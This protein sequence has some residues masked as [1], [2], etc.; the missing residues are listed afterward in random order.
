C[1]SNSKCPLREMKHCPAPMTPVVP[2]PQPRSQAGCANEPETRPCEVP[3]FQTVLYRMRRPSFSKVATLAP[4]P[5]VP[6]DH[7]V[8]PPLEKI[9]R[10]PLLCMVKYAPGLPQVL[11]CHVIWLSWRS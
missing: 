9:T 2:N 5:E 10:L 7:R 3:E 11:D 8:T 1:N 4:E 6:L